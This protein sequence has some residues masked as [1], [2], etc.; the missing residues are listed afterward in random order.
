[1]IDYQVAVEQLLA[2]TLKKVTEVTGQTGA[3]ACDLPTYFAEF[4]DIATEWGARF[5]AEAD[6]AIAEELA[7]QAEFYWDSAA[8][9]EPTRQVMFEQ[10]QEEAVAMLDGQI[11]LMREV[12]KRLNTRAAAVRGVSPDELAAREKLL[13]P[14]AP[15]PVMEGEKDS[16][17]D[18]ESGEN[19][20]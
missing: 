17:P 9:L 6:E 20:Q 2:D 12:S 16:P 7:R 10:A 18:P 13:Q 1:M 19:P 15:Q 8:L 14:A 11:R 4:R 3:A 5:A